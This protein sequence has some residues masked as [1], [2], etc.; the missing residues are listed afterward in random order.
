VR[1]DLQEDEGVEMQMAPLIDCVF[2]LIIFFLVSTVMKKLEKELDVDLPKPATKIS[3]EVKKKPDMLIVSID[4]Q[5]KFHLGANPVSLELLHAKLK[6]TA[7][8]NPLK[9]VRIDGDRYAPFESVV[10]ILEL[11]KLEGLMNVGIHTARDEPP[12]P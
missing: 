7:L 11:C 4:R 1:I 3:R 10:H 12:K 8:T 2:L 5:G 9:R 6:E